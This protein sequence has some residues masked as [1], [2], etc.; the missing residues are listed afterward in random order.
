LSPVEFPRDEMSLP[1]KKGCPTCMSKE[2]LNVTCRPIDYENLSVQEIL[3]AERKNRNNISILCRKCNDLARNQSLHLIVAGAETGPGARPCDSDWL[4]LV[5]D[6]CAAAGVPFF[7]KQVNAKGDRELD[8][9][10]H[11]DWI[12][13]ER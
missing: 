10:L 13:R 9:I 11:D 5:R 3:D 4:R 2:S 12:E 7:L 1:P 8:G 6:Q